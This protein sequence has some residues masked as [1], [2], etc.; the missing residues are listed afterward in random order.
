MNRKTRSADFL[1]HSIGWC[2]AALKTVSPSVLAVAE[3][4]HD[5]DMVQHDLFARWIGET[6]RA[7]L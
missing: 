3:D 6:V 5:D 2:V 4:T 7:Q 1:R